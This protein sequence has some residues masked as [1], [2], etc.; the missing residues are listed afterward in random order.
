MP[1]TSHSSSTS[2]HPQGPLA[3]GANGNGHSGGQGSAAEALA[4]GS[5]SFVAWLA[6]MVSVVKDAAHT[7]L[8]ISLP[9]L[10]RLLA[11]LMQGGEV[12]RAMAEVKVPPDVGPHDGQIPDEE[13]RIIRVFL[14]GADK[15][16]DEFVKVIE[17]GVKVPFDTA[18]VGQMLDR[19]QEL[20]GYVAMHEPLVAKAKVALRVLGVAIREA[21][22]PKYEKARN[23]ASENAVLAR[24]FS[25]VFKYYGRLNGVKL[26]AERL[27]A[28]EQARLAAQAEKKKRADDEDQ[29][30]TERETELQQR[31]ALRK[32]RKPKK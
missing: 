10:G 2:S 3:G 8:T 25:E 31:A 19:Y 32:P 13:I 22:K 20:K 7:L 29:L 18:A 23:N 1:R 4:Q 5:A 26:E 16:P 30:E 6:S 21:Y 24:T 28:G 14:A 17:G 27:A 12:F 11:P 9:D 15:M